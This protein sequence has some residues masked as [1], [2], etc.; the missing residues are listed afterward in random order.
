VPQC[1]LIV[2]HVDPQGAPPDGLAVSRQ[3]KG[4]SPG[5]TGVA[6]E[7]FREMS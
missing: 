5:H 3:V 6:S 1:A 7:I 2:K 4:T